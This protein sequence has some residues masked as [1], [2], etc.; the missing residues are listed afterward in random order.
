MQY[1]YHTLHDYYTLYDQRQLVPGERF[2]RK[3]QAKIR[4][5]LLEAAA[6]EDVEMLVWH[7]VGM[8]N[9][10][11]LLYGGEARLEVLLPP[12]HDDDAFAGVAVRPPEELTLMAAEGGGK[13]EFRPERVEG[14]GLPAAISGH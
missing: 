9:G 10:G 2:I 11:D 7:G 14:S 4:Q 12:I 3:R 6:I 8:R 13:A 1:K 5:G